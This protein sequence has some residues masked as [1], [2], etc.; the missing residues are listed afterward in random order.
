MDGLRVPTVAHRYAGSGAHGPHCPQIDSAAAITFSSD[1]SRVLIELASDPALSTHEQ[2]HLID[3]SIAASGFS[4]DKAEVFLAL[5]SNP[6]MT[7]ETRDYLAERLADAGLFSS[8]QARV[9][10]RL[11]TK[12]DASGRAAGT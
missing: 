6:S 5:A 3:V 12:D 1:R 4:G 11:V 9:T 2:C 8:D 7:P 10:A